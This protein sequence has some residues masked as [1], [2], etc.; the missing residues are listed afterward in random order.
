MLGD[1]G[2]LRIMYCLKLRAY[3]TFESRRTIGSPI[4]R[5]Y[6][7]YNDCHVK[8]MATTTKVDWK[9]HLPMVD[10]IVKYLRTL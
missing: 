9:T 10:T 2:M 7:Q 8:C 4:P 5:P 1:W 6:R 3:I